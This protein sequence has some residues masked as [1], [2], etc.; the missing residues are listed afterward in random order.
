M[1]KFQIH[2]SCTPL[3]EPIT[4]RSNASERRGPERILLTFKHVPFQILPPLEECDVTMLLFLFGL[5]TH[6]SPTSLK[7]SV[8]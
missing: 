6:F 8:V 1:Q 4:H 7:S 5:F 3:C 2:I